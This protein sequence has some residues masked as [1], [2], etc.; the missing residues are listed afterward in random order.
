MPKVSI[1]MP[2]Y[3][4]EQYLAQALESIIYQ[5]FKDWELILINDGSTD[6]SDAIIRQY[7]D[8]RIYYIINEQNLGLIKTLNKGI[9]YCHGKY[10]A[11]MDADDIAVADRLGRQVDFLNSHS[12]YLMCG[13]NAIVVDSNGRKTGSIKNL[14]DNDMLQVNLL[15]SVPF[16][17]PTVMVHREVLQHNQYDE[18]Y[19]HIEDYE[20]WYRIAKLGK[21][22]NIDRNLLAYR[23]HDTNVS[24]VHDKEQERL[25]NDII[26]NQLKELDLVPTEKELYCHRITFRLYDMGKK[27]NV[28]VEQFEDVSDWFTKLLQQNK[29]KKIYKQ[30]DMQAFLWSRWAVL[31]ISQKRYSKILFPRFRSFN[32]KV[33]VKFIKLLFFLK[34]K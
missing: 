4:A 1:L 34:D 5:D 26:C 19:K 25:K 11:R 15:F 3:N 24:V 16:I 18:A 21:I 32:P 29:K 30:A 28:S 6:T 10:I 8:E 27:Q 33:F 9:H 13:T 12:D 17:H 23:W 14:P 31:C 7:E 20:L 2:V 22:A